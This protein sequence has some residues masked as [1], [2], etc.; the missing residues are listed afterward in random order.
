MTSLNVGDIVLDD[1]DSQ[2]SPAAVVNLPPIEAT[3]WDLSHCDRSVADD[4]PKYDPHEEIAIVVFKTTLNYHYPK[5]TG[6]LPIK[7]S[8]LST[9]GANFYVFPRSRL[10]QINTLDPVTI[11]INSLSPNRY[12]SR[13]FSY[14]DNE[15]FIKE[16]AERGQPNPIPLVRQVDTDEYEIIS[17]NKRVWAAITGGLSEIEC[18]VAYLS[19][20][21]AAQ[22]W[23][24][25]HLHEYTPE[26]AHNALRSLKKDYQDLEPLK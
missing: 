23:A 15:D 12:H 21:Q 4:N 9:D 6:G 5:Y 17:G 1:D 18:D 11:S 10:K 16:I 25:R 24:A 14:D 3:E 7:I 2:P 13:N 8:K 20:T 26:Q 19:D 22:K